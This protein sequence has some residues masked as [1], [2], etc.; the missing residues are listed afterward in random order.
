MN[1]NIAWLEWAKELQFLAQCGLTYCNDIYDI[2]RYERIREI[3]AEMVQRQT[4]IPLENIKEVFCNETGF[5][6][7]KLDTRAAIIQDGKILLVQEKDGRWSLPG[8]WVDVNQSVR[9]NTI[10]EVLEEAGL[11]VRA[12]RLVALHDR[13]RRNQPIYIHE[14]CKIFVLCEI[15]SGQFRPNSE[16][17]GSGFFAPDALP[18]LAGE[19]NN[20]DQVRMCFEAHADEHWPVVFD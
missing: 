14:I 9:E 5:Q 18:P 11:E 7:P 17:I 13:N 10:K 19:K 20:T 16:T 15:I 12:L 1:S 4:N 8:G 3:S 6:T 2:E